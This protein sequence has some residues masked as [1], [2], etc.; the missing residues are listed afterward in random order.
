MGVATKGPAQPDNPTSPNA[1]QVQQNPK[2]A[3]CTRAV[4]TQR[5]PTAHGAEM[6][7][8][9]MHGQPAQRDF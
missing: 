3:S 8:Y 4:P 1:A 9:I 5:S 6:R 2:A 7:I